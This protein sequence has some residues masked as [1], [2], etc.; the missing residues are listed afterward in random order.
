MRVEALPFAVT[1]TRVGYYL[2]ADRGAAEALARLVGPL[3]AGATIP[4]RDYGKL[5][6]D[7]EPGRID[8]WVES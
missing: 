4:V 1:T 5:L 8:L 7:P 2:E 3:S 6:D